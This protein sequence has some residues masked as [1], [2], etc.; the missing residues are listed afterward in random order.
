MLH[1]IEN[2]DFEDNTI[3]TFSHLIHSN[4]FNDSKIEFN[5]TC[6]RQ[7]FYH[8]SLTIILLIKVL[9]NHLQILIRVKISRTDNQHSCEK[10]FIPLQK[11][12][13]EHKSASRTT[14]S[15]ANKEKHIRI[16]PRPLLPS[17]NTSKKTIRLHN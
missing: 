8:S 11:V 4:S 6:L 5:Q 9:L 12:L 14:V 3:S 16:L 2:Y 17:M 13:A 15:I 10:A 7:K 1:T